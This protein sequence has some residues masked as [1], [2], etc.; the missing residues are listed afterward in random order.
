[1]RGCFCEHELGYLC[2]NGVEGW[3]VRLWGGEIW[4]LVVVGVPSGRCLLLFVVRRT[5]LA[6]GRVKAGV[7]GCAMTPTRAARGERE[8]TIECGAWVPF[9]GHWSR[10]WQF[11]SLPNRLEDYETIADDWLSVVQCLHRC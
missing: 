7:Q 2:P 3:V 8:F 1:M 5:G 4:L 9:T 10:V 6:C 11:M